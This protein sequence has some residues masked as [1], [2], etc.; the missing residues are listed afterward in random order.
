MHCPFCKMCVP[1]FS[2]H[3]IVFGVCIGA[4][5]EL[6]VILFFLS[7]V[8]FECYFLYKLTMLFDQ[9]GAITIT[10]QYILNFTVLYI[11]AV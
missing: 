9:F 8:V 1:K 5:N 4:A 7:M 10:I 3:S 2:R 6:L 11:S